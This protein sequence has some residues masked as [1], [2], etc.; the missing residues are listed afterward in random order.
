MNRGSAPFAVAAVLVSVLAVGCSGHSRPAALPAAVPASS[1]AGT[2]TNSATPTPSVAAASTASAVASSASSV[3]PSSSASSVGSD[4]TSGP[5]GPDPAAARRAAEQVVH[6]Y[7]AAVNTAIRSRDFRPLEKR[8]LPSCAACV[9]EVSG[10]QRIF[11]VA[12][13]V[14]GGQLAVNSS[15]A[16]GVGESNLITVRASVT[17]A[18]GKIVDRTGSTVDSFN[19][20]SSMLDFDVKRMPTG[21]FIV[22]NITRVVAP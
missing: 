17:E 12:N 18:S 11:A 22:A 9:Q 8:F 14:N 5:F 15:V 16:G 20:S 10:F 2:P 1:I 21:E 4:S 7:Y 3:S 6:D 19:S 13:V